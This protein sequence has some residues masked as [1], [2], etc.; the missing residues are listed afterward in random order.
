MVAFSPPRGTS[1][2]ALT[3]ADRV[4]TLAITCVDGS[5]LPE[6]CLTPLTAGLLADPK[7]ATMP[8]LAEHRCQDLP[9]SS[10]FWPTRC[11]FGAACRSRLTP[12]SSALSELG[13]RAG[14]EP[15]SRSAAVRRAPCQLRILPLPASTIWRCCGEL[16]DLQR[17][18]ALPLA[19]GGIGLRSAERGRSAAYWASWAD[20]LPMIQE[21]HPVVAGNLAAMLAAGGQSGPSVRAAAEV[22]FSPPRGTSCCV[23]TR[24]DRVETLAITPVDGS[25]LPELCLRPLTAGLLAESC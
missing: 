16:D 12:P 6:L 19:R 3:R 21:Q 17:R 25:V 1:C 24:A 18:R 10:R 14:S 15:P 5:V 22:A 23:L 13:Q 11:P 8:G 20:T 9:R 2:C 4:E 7:Q